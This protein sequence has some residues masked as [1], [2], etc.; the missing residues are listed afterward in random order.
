M[1]AS[2]RRGAADAAH[3]KELAADDGRIVAQPQR[4]GYGH[5]GGEHGLE[6]GKLLRPAM[7]DRHARGRRVAAQHGFQPARVRAAPDLHIKQPVLLHR[8]TRQQAG[9]DYVCRRRPRGLRDEALN[10]LA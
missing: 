3:D 8:A 6:Q 2:S 10:G 4:L 1:R 7:A 9:V 5:A